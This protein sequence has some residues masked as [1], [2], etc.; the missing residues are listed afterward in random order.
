MKMSR[1][2]VGGRGVGVLFTLVFNSSNQLNFVACALFSKDQ[3]IYGG[4]KE[5]LFGF[6]TEA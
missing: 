4:K 3:L 5:F 2:G 1:G 6:K